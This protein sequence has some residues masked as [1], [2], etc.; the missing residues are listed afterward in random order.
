VLQVLLYKQQFLIFVFLAKK[1]AEEFQCRQ[2]MFLPAAGGSFIPTGMSLM[3]AM[4]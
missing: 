2:D 1:Q 3:L 4:H